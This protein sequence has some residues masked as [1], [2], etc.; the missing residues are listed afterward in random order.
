MEL[1]LIRH[2]RPVRI[3]NADGPADP[4]LDDEGREQARRLA[5]WLRHE[6][7]DAV[8]TSP[9]RRARETAA[10]LAA[11]TGHEVVVDDELAEF[12][13]DAHFYIHYE[14]LK[15]A[16]DERW[17]QMLTGDWAEVDPAT[18]QRVVVGA[19]ER[20]VDAHPGQRVAVVCHG[21]VV[22]AYAAHLL[23]LD[24]PLFFEPAYTSISRVQAARTGERSI[25]SLNE[26][27]HLV[28]T[29][30]AA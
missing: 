6:Q 13:R 16:K 4:E 19:I 3:E 25:L 11:V 28:G 22:N 5:G 21:G 14:E 20:I 7:I 9:L 12:D 15:A 29:R 2:G 24:Y 27:G 1:L 23:K 10:P 18:F 26:T 30:D 17:Q 8:Y